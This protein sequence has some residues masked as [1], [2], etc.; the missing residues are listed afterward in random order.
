MTFNIS[1]IGHTTGG[2]FYCN[3]EDNCLVLRMAE[4]SL[5]DASFFS[6]TLH[7]GHIGATMLHHNAPHVLAHRVRGAPELYST[8]SFAIGSGRHHVMH[9][10][11]KHMQYVQS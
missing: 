1:K 4:P 9:G 10:F 2:I 11:R 8:N 3:N 6:D 5:S 7:G